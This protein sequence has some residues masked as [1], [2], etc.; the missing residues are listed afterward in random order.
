[1]TSREPHNP[2]MIWSR[3]CSAAKFDSSGG[4]SPQNELDLKLRIDRLSNPFPIQD[5]IL[6]IN[7]L[8]PRFSYVMP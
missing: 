3:I 1:M 5:G 7:L 4:S 6:P 2:T 8:F